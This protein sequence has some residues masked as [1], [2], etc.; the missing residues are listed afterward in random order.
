NGTAKLP[1]PPA[2]TL[3][4]AKPRWRP[5]SASAVG[6]SSWPLFSGYAGS[7]HTPSARSSYWETMMRFYEGQHRFYCGI[8]LHARSMHVC[9]LDQ[10]GTAVFDK[11]LASRPETLLRA[12]APFRDGLVVGVEC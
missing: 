9:I 1:G 8:D 6:Y 4:R 11:N 3:Y 7:C 2:T 12:I 5:R 10:A